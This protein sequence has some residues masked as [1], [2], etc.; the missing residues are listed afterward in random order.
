MRCYYAVHP[1]L[2]SAAETGET[3]AHART[4]TYMISRSSSDTETKR[5]I[6]GGSESFN[7]EESAGFPVCQSV[8]KSPVAPVGGSEVRSAL[9]LQ[10]QSLK[11]W[12]N[13]EDRVYSLG[14]HHSQLDSHHLAVCCVAKCVTFVLLLS[15]QEFF[16]FYEDKKTKET[17]EE[18]NSVNLMDGGVNAVSFSCCNFKVI[19]FSLR[20]WATCLLLRPSSNA[21]KRAENLHG[22]NLQEGLRS[23]TNRDDWAK[24][25]ERITAHLWPSDLVVGILRLFDLHHHHRNVSCHHCRHQVHPC[26]WSTLGWVPS[27]VFFPFA[28]NA[29]SCIRFQRGGGA[30]RDHKYA[31][32]LRWGVDLW[33]RL[34][35]S[36]SEFCFVLWVVQDAAVLSS[37]RKVLCPRQLFPAL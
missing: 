16:Q 7:S 37:F 22:G 26:R 25:L 4:R 5:M 2:H 30:F 18:E 13:A 6:L 33:M 9:S 14:E 8:E 12:L 11:W 36:S 21:S 19:F 35:N 31:R 24:K 15:L 23:Q 34:Y 29:A 1:I 28:A 17:S 3:H 10:G 32:S 27:R 20:R